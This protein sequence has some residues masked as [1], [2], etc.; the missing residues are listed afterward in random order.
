VRRLADTVKG[1]TGDIAWI[2]EELKKLSSR[3][4]KCCTHD[5]LGLLKSRLDQIEK[6]L[7]DLRKLVQKHDKMIKGLGGAGGG[8]NFNAGPDID[9][10]KLDQL[11]ALLDNLRKEFEQFRDHSLKNL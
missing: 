8:A 7:M 9:S 6:S 1:H 5:D 11:Q 2:K 3:I 4:D 10:E